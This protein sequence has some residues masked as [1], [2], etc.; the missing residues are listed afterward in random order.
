MLI[1]AIQVSR[2]MDRHRAGPTRQAGRRLPH[3]PRNSRHSASPA[4]KAGSHR[5]PDD[6]RDRASSYEGCPVLLVS[7]KPAPPR[8][9]RPRIGR[10]VGLAVVGA[11]Q[12]TTRSLPAIATTHSA[13][14]RRCKRL[15]VPCPVRRAI[16]RG[17]PSIRYRV[18]RGFGP[19]ETGHEGRKHGLPI[20]SST[21]ASRAP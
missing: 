8:D 9:R 16:D 15:N 5:R 1:R 6:D 21:E 10:T 18:R 17:L 12:P 7:Q 11:C 19:Y 14:N 3:L 13:G 2:R 4:K 20:I